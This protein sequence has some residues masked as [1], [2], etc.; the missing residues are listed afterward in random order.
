M[1]ARFGTTRTEHRTQM[2][3]PRHYSGHRVAAIIRWGSRDGS[4]SKGEVA[5]DRGRWNGLEGQGSAVLV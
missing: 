1:L 5:L 2:W 3:V 4:L